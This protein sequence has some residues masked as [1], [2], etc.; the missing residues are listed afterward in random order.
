MVYGF[1]CG[2]F[3][4]F[5]LFSNYSVDETVCTTMSDGV[6]LTSA[7]FTP[8]CE[9]RMIHT[10]LIRTPML[11]SSVCRILAQVG[12]R[13]I[14]QDTRG[15]WNSEGSYESSIL[16]FE[17]SDGCDTVQW[18]QDTYP[19][20]KIGLLG[21]SYLGYVQW[22]TIAGLIERDGSS[23][24]VAYIM[25]MFCSSD[26]YST[27]FTGVEGVPSIDFLTRFVM[28]TFMIGRI[29]EP[30]MINCIYYAYKTMLQTKPLVPHT[31]PHEHIQEVIQSLLPGSDMYHTK[32]DDEFWTARSH[33]DALANAPSCHIVAGWYDFF[34]EGALVDYRIMRAVDPSTRLTIGPW[35][36]LQTTH[37]GTFGMLLREII[38]HFQQYMEPCHLPIHTTVV[39]E[40]VRVFL[41]ES[42]D[43][44]QW[45]SSMGYMIDRMRSTIVSI[46]SSKGIQ[47][48]GKWITL[49]SWPPIDTSSVQMWLSHDGRLVGESLLQTTTNGDASYTFDSSNPT[50]SGFHYYNGGPFH[51]SKEVHDRSDAVHFTTGVLTSGVVLAGHM[52]ATLVCFYTGAQSV[53][54]VVRIC[55]VYPDDTTVVI[56]EGIQRIRGNDTTTVNVDV[57]S[58]G[59]I[60]KPGL[61]LRIYIC[62]SSYPRWMVNSGN[63]DEHVHTPTIST[64]RIRCDPG[65]L[66]SSFII[67]PVYGL[68]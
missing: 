19:G 30:G 52:S 10:I 16:G 56:A 17:K 46:F 43:I 3:Q 68:E 62:S 51:V 6:V 54:Y 48:P 12:Y 61:R 22:A 18:I 36:H 40:P 32:K 24:A 15:R 25:P 26:M 20:S 65:H 1:R 38:T 11:L 8:I 4:R 14:S 63:N 31:V 9:D 2:I 35:H 66:N 49:S 13:V 64:H 37:Q 23:E 34:L 58:I 57:G 42:I 47:V 28:S 39:E 59:R 21:I 33:R 41:P 55:E 60:V 67:F 7:I 5:P 27:C 50:P 53:D 29:D 45:G 44:T